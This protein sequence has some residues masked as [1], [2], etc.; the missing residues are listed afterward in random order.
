VGT[1]RER[2]F[3]S[4]D[5]LRLYFRDYG[6]ARAGGVPV[7]CLSGLTRNCKD[8]H[9]LAI[10][11]SADRRVLCP[12]YRGRGRSEYDRDRWRYNARTYLEDIR[13]L[14]A[15]ANIHRVVVIGTSLGGILAMAM[16]AAMPA[17]LAGAVLNDIGPAVDLDGLGRVIAF[18]ANQRPPSD[19]SAAVGHLREFLPN[20]PAESDAEWLRI[21]QNTYREGDDGILRFDWDPALIEPFRRAVAENVDLWP[22]FRALRGVPV[23]VVRGALSDVLTEKTF[24]RMSDEMPGLHGLTVDTVGHA[25][26]LSEP[27]V[28]EAID[29][30]LAQ[31]PNPHRR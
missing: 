4:R 31:L 20:L 28:L 24:R 16:A 27:H 18:Y 2:Q 13:H 9:D 15:V 6:D 11:L 3:T 17:V 26:S 7:L 25:P 14:L 12:D 30:L 1:Y 29:V 5:G 23:L 10:H 19:W 22:L 21:A 8:F